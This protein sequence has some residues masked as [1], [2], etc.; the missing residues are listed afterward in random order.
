VKG[1]IRVGGLTSDPDQSLGDAFDDQ[2]FAVILH[3]EWQSERISFFAEGLYMDL[4][5]DDTAPTGGRSTELSHGIFE[6]GFGF[7]M[8]HRSLGGGDGGWPHIHV[9]PIAGARLQYVDASL[10]GTPGA[11]ESD[12]WIDGFAGVRARLR[13]NGVVAMFGRVDLGGGGADFVWNAQAGVDIAFTPRIRLV[14]GYR[15]LDTDYRTDDFVYDT[16]LQGPLL[17]VTFRF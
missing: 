16:L 7:A 12:V 4:A 10:E 17:G 14:G 6:T 11:D 2:N 1:E 8:L 9:E 15:W 3:A 13:F 5:A